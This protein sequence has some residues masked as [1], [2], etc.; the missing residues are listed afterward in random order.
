MLRGCSIYLGSSRK[1]VLIARLSMTWR[2]PMSWRRTRFSLMTQGSALLFITCC[3]TVW[4]LLTGVQSRSQSELLTKLR[5]SKSKMSWTNKNKKNWKRMPAV[6]KSI[7]AHSHQILSLT[8]KCNCNHLHRLLLFKTWR[9][10]L[11][12]WKMQNKSICVFP[13][14]TQVVEWII[15]SDRDAS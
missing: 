2:F 10:K 3:Q 9:T 5:I 8:R 6:V 4:S 7:K 13:S 14:L 11:T 15:N 12:I 1:I